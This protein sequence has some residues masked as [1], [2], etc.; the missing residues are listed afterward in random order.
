[1]KSRKSRLDNLSDQEL[2]A[3]FRKTSGLFGEAVA[4]WMPAGKENDRLIALLQELRRR[5]TQVRLQLA[6]LLDERNRF[7][8]YY[9]AKHLLGLIPSRS[10]EIIEAETKEG[11]AIAGDAG[12]LLD[13]VDSGQYKP[14]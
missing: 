1:M 5:G 10:R 11:D 13:R 4:N 9:A 3:E 8:R 14:D 7:V 2:V 6:P 12:M